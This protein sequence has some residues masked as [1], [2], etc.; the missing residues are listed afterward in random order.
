MDVATAHQSGAGELME[1]AGRIG[2]AADEIVDP[3]TELTFAL[4]RR[5]CG[6]CVAKQRCRL[7]MQKPGAWIADVMLSL[8]GVMAYA[9]PVA[10]VVGGL[11]TLKLVA[12]EWSVTSLRAAGWLI[13]ILC[14]EETAIG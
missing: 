10:F 9:I 7:A 11:R 13:G 14:G 1:L 4:A 12:W 8:F 5:R 3:A 6:T 2:I